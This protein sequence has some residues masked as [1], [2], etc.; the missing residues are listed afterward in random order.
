MYVWRGQRKR[1][2]LNGESSPAPVT[3]ETTSPL[4]EGA[5]LGVDEPICRERERER[6]VVRRRRGGGGRGVSSAQGAVCVLRGPELRV[7]HACRAVR[8]ARVRAA[9][10]GQRL[11]G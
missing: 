11:L 9:S 8:E 5:P 7:R 4:D 6:E 3:L 1:V 2:D 10:R